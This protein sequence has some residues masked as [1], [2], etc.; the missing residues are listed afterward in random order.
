MKCPPFFL[1]LHAST[2]YRLL[3]LPQFGR[4]GFHEGRGCGQDCTHVDTGLV[5]GRASGIGKITLAIV[6]KEQVTTATKLKLT[7]LGTVC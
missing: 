1:Y 5:D 3:C 6:D 7:V 4:L 2:T